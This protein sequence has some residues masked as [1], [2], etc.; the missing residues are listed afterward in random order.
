MPNCS[1]TTGHSPS[2]HVTKSSSILRGGV[3]G[4]GGGGFNGTHTDNVCVILYTLFYIHSISVKT[5]YY[6]PWFLAK[7]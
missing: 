1:H 2:F 3:G 5:P 7:I 4:G 6:S